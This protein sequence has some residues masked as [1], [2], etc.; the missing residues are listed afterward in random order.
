MQSAE[1]IITAEIKSN[2]SLVAAGL[3]SSRVFHPLAW[4]QTRIIW[5]NPGLKS[6]QKREKTKFRVFHYLAR[7][8]TE[9]IPNNSGLKSRQEVKNTW[10]YRTGCDDNKRWALFCVCIFT[11]GTRVRDV[12]WMQRST[13]GPRRCGVYIDWSCTQARATLPASFHSV[14]RW[15]FQN[16]GDQ[17][18]TGFG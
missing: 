17:L 11:T 9:I 10:T 8:Q 4:F 7:F 15:W 6:R 16:N 5:N 14:K 12:L 3:V 18:P 13:A 1:T 2:L